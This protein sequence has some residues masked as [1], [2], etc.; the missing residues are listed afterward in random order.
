[1]VDDMKPFGERRLFERKSCSRMI[2]IDD[3]EDS[4]SGHMRDLAVGGALIEPPQGNETRIG[5]ELM[6]TIPF[7]LRNDHIKIKAKVA[8]IKSIGMGVRFIKSSADSRNFR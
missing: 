6:L 7:G 2:M 5:Q 1:M 3:H 8:W 4:Y